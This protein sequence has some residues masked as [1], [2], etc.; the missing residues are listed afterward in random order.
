MGI[1]SCLRSLKSL[2]KAG[3]LKGEE[4]KKTRE[5][6]VPTTRRERNAGLTRVCN[7]LGEGVV[8][9]EGLKEK[10]QRD[11]EGPRAD[12]RCS[13]PCCPGPSVQIAWWVE[14]KAFP[15]GMLRMEGLKMT[16]TE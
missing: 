15:N 8:N 16:V 11:M 10:K 12:G 7:G 14:R 6:D 2:A 9:A 13:G 3:E 4:K 5:D 1:A